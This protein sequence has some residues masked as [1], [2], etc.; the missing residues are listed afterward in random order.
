MNV[1][2][3]HCKH[4]RPALMI[5]LCLLLAAA[6]QAQSRMDSPIVRPLPLPRQLN[7]T[8]TL[9]CGLPVYG[10]FD[11]RALVRSWT[12]SADCVLPITEYDGAFT[13]YLHFMGEASFEID[14]AGHTIYGP[15]DRALLFLESGSRLTLRNVII[16]GARFPLDECWGPA[17]NQS[18]CGATM[19]VYWG[20]ELI[21][22]NV[23]VRNS[24]PG[25]VLH[26]IGGSADFTNLSALFNEQHPSA[27]G[28]GIFKVLDTD[29]RYANTALTIRHG[30][31]CGNRYAQNLFYL[32]GDAAVSLDGNLKI[33]DNTWVN[34]G[35]TQPMRLVAREESATFAIGLDARHSDCD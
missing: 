28:S 24:G 25:G 34:S 21:A 9:D 26:M 32:L 19:Y 14:G 35:Q 30:A 13:E 5:A 4:Y 1:I 16:D 20:A 27:P 33:S 12:L 15:V 11:E 10:L 6:S 2:L 23:V 18:T 31:F 17:D 3:N 29:D 8:E 7:P 22:K